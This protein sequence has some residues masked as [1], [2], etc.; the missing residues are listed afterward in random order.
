MLNVT[1]ADSGACQLIYGHPWNCL[2]DAWRG[3]LTNSGRVNK[4]RRSDKRWSEAKADTKK[5]G[6]GERA[7]EGGEK[8][9]E[10]EREP[11]GWT[12]RM[13]VHV[14]GAD[15]CWSAPKTQGQTQTILSDGTV[16]CL[17]VCLTDEHTGV[18]LALSNQFNRFTQ[19]IWRRS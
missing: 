11:S 9:R 18:C 19:W 1:L 12:R 2:S 7:R 8:K 6:E 10:R 5:E 14:N 17:I 15:I 16:V 3:W 4:S 13:R